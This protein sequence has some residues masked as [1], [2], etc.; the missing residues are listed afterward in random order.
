MPAT[1]IAIER[2]R[3]APDEVRKIADCHA[4]IG[5]LQKGEELHIVPQ[6]SGDDRFVLQTTD[7]A[8][9]KQLAEWLKGQK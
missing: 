5:G 6:P 8:R 2:I 1:D 7:Q 3:L 4:K 9:A